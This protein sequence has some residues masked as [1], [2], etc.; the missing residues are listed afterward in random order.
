MLDDYNN[1]TI[2][3]AF[4]S[5]NEMVYLIIEEHALTKT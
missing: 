5:T 1:V 4:E 3:L 2:I